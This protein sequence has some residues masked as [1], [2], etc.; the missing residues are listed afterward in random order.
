MINL[1]INI[2]L[3]RIGA[4]KYTLEALWTTSKQKMAKLSLS[5]LPSLFQGFERI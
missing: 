2:A 1:P 3:L 5:E 4:N